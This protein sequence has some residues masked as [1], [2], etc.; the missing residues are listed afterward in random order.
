VGS[1][2]ALEM[3]AAAVIGSD[4]FRVADALRARFEET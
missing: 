2:P 3:Y 1:W 4:P